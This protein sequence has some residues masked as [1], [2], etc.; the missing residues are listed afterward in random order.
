MTLAPEPKKTD[1]Y[2]LQKGSNTLF[3][4]F[5]ALQSGAD[6]RFQF[7]NTLSQNSHDSLFL[8]DGL[9]LWYQLGAKH[10]GKDLDEMA[11][12]LRTIAEGYSH[13]VAVGASMG[14]YAALAL[15]PLIGADTVLSIAGQSFIDQKHRIKYADFRWPN[16]MDM[17]R[18]KAKNTKYQDLRPIFMN[19]GKTK[20]HM[21]Y[22]EFETLDRIHAMRMAEFPSVNIYEMRG[23][24]H[25]AALAM[26]ESGTFTGVLSNLAN[27]KP[28][29][30]GIDRRFILPIKDDD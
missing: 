10:V 17:I 2:H 28:V 1:I 3:I 8:K 12:T 18:A 9:D 6:Q 22:G 7:Y 16:R 24:T 15:G 21:I 26:K 29:L 4:C 25:W 5:S 27:D 19:N 13:V 11:I 23:T 30:E 20:V 14:G